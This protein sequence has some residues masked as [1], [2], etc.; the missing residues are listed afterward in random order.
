MLYRTC[1]T[2]GNRRLVKN[3]NPIFASQ[4]DDL[5]NE[6]NQK[7]KTAQ[8]GYDRTGRFARLTRELFLP[9][10]LLASGNRRLLKNAN[11][12]FASQKDDL[13]NEGNQK[14]KT[15]QGGLSFLALPT[16][17]EPITNP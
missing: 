15:A 1:Y 11:P 3:A 4:K 10:R 2:I 13:I 17:I 5:I 8:G 12:I 16:G 9:T 7:G 6:G 14:G